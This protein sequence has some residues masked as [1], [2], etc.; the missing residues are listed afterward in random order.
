MRLRGYI[1]AVHAAD[2]VFDGFSLLADFG[3]ASVPDTRD[4]TATG[5]LGILPT[6]PARVRDD[7]D[8][9]VMVLNSESEVVRAYPVRQSDT[10]R[11]RYWE[12]AGVTLA[13]GIDPVARLAVMTR[14]EVAADEGSGRADLP[15][16]ANKLSFMAVNKAALQLAQSWLLTGVAPPIQP[17]V[18]VD[19]GPPPV[20]RRDRDGNALGGIRIPDMAVPTASHVGLRGEDG[21]NALVGVSRPFDQEHLRA[22]YPDRIA[23]VDA[24]RDRHRRVRD[25]GCGA[26]GRPRRPRGPRRRGG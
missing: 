11:F 16:D 24:L 13:A 12:V 5:D 22:R 1:N 8:E 7:L 20:T 6:V 21:L 14:D 26:R 9:P 19:P 10:K 2:R 23:F 25:R 17:R 4:A 15:D 18:D 3:V